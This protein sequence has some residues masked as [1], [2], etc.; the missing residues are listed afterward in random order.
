LSE[1]ARD[2][3]RR[4]ARRASLA[5]LAVSLLVIVTAAVAAARLAESRGAA[6]VAGALEEAGLDWASV[7]AN[8]LRVALTGTAP[9]DRARF[10]ALD[11]AGAAV[12]PR[13]LEDRMT[14][15]PPEPAAA[16]APPAELRITR[17]GEVV[18]LAGRVPEGAAPA[19]VL[20]RRLPGAK[21]TDLTRTDAA[22]TE[23]WTP[24]LS[25]A[26]AAITEIGDGR[27][28]AR[29]GEV[30]VAARAD[31]AEGAARLKAALAGHVPEGVTLITAIE[32]PPPLLSPYTLRLSRGPSGARF[33]ACAAP[34][35]AQVRRIVAAAREIGLTG[36]VR[37]PVALGVPSVDW[38]GAATRAIA[39]LGE[40]GTGTL[41]ISD[42]EVT[43]IGSSGVKE[44]RFRA[45]VAALRRDLP[46]GFSLAARRPVPPMSSRER[47]EGEK[48]TLGLYF[49]GHPIEDY[50]DELRQ[51]RSSAISELRAGRQT[52]IVA[53]LVVSMRVLRSRRGGAMA[54]VVLDDRSGRIEA[55]LFPEVYERVRHKVV[56]DAVLVAEG[57][58][59][60]D[61]YTGDL[62]LRVEQVHSISEARQH[63]SEGLEI[64]CGA[65][66]AGDLPERLRRTLG[67]YR[68]PESGCPV[69][70]RVA[71]SVPPGRRA[72][73]RIRL[74]REWQV[75]PSDD[76]LAGLRDEF[77]SDRVSLCYGPD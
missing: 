6:R 38:A 72:R 9:S 23:G 30:R 51:F 35:P 34:D 13:R 47:L 73:G 54:F 36:A 25:A 7:S 44:D 11:A 33:D 19:A 65:G 53:G 20:A 42:S 75:A 40:I 41:T 70:V 26:L 32:A 59:Q 43:L 76:L 61:D 67:P 18:T 4:L 22:D 31:S 58:V 60:P 15:R 2:S 66:A 24:A 14:V 1:A 21:L 16:P 50:L 69:L 77:G 52:Q 68:V 45:A 10:A 27:I 12:A 56:K 74:G 55:S 37:C 29:P 64:D 3:R 8:G 57:E 17:A 48:E 5:A 46:R 28:R 49:S 71:V 62:K 39:A 63:F